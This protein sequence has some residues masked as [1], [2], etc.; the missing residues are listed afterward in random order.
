MGAGCCFVILL[1]FFALFVLFGGVNSGSLLLSP[2]FGAQEFLVFGL[3]V[4]FVLGLV[5]PVLVRSGFCTVCR[6]SRLQNILY[7]FCVS[8]SMRLSVVLFLY[9]P[10]CCYAILECSRICFFLCRFCCVDFV[11]GATV[12]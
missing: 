2:R 8:P 10:Y 7:S 11:C 6:F 3:L 5:A 9:C 4:Y 12:R 1:L